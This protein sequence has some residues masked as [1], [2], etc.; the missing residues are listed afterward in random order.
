[1]SKRILSLKEVQSIYDGI[2]S[3]YDKSLWLFY[4]LG[5][6]VRAYREAAVESLNLK[7]GDTVVDLG[8]GTGLNFELLEKRIGPGGQIIGV[9]LTESMLKQAQQRID[10]SGWNNV[11]LIQR[12]M[13][14]FKIPDQADVILSTFALTMSPDYDKIIERISDS[15][16]P[17]KRFSILELKKPDNWPDWLVRAM[18]GL[19]K[20][21]G[22]RM[23]HAER[24]PWKSIQRHF[25]ESYI[26]EY[27]SGAVY[28]ATGVKSLS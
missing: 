17:G 15:L 13:G 10:K 12:D 11:T 16:E 21:Y 9:D 23:E 18:I 26:R 27:Y 2:A 7:E 28:V 6:R 14:R 1:M 24:K 22:T 5:F 19:L 8:C 25:R 3:G 20:T 4:L